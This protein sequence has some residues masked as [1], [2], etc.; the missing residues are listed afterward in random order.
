MALLEIRGKASVRKAAGGAGSG[1]Y[2]EYVDKLVKLIPAE[3]VGIYVAGLAQIP[4][5]LSN[6]STVLLIWIFICFLL[7]I[8]TRIFYTKDPGIFANWKIVIIS[9][10][11]F[12]IWAYSLLGQFQNISYYVSWIGALALLVWTFI[13]PKVYGDA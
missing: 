5:D 9:A 6:L 7:V 8:G 1:T 11:S 4:K 3:V 13:A 12:V 10:I 2:N